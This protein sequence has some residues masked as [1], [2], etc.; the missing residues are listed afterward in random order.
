VE[1][2]KREWSAERLAYRTPLEAFGTGTAA[3]ISPIGGLDWN[4]SFVEV[5][6]GKTGPLTQRLYNTITGIQYRILE[7]PFGWMV[8]VD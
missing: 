6:G 2:F 1:R 4:A 7:D 8:Q 3:V 5:N